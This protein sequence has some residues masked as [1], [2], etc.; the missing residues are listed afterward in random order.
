MLCL[1]YFLRGSYSTI[2]VDVCIGATANTLGVNLNVVQ[3]N[4]RTV[5]LTCYDCNH[6]KSS[7]NLF[8]LFVPPSKKGKNLDGHYNCYVNQDY[9]N[10]MKL[11]SIHILSSLLKKINPKSWAKM[12]HQ[13]HQIMCHNH[14]WKLPK[15]KSFI[16]MI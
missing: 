7:M 8:L 1:D 9:S 2:V 12:Q 3:K 16:S 14:Q 5:S 15:C 13:H 10:R 6:Y 4:Q 11:P